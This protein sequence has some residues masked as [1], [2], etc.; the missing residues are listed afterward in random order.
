MTQDFQHAIAPGGISVKVSE[1]P[2]GS[3]RYVLQVP[4]ASIPVRAGLP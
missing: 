2:D 3:C 1:Q 4:Q